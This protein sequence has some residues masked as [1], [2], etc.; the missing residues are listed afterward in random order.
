[1]LRH[2]EGDV[3]SRWRIYQNLAAM[4]MNGGAKEAK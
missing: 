1:L 3:Q 2:A 4:S